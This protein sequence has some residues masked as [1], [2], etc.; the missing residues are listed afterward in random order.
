MRRGGRTKPT[1]GRGRKMAHGGT[2]HCGHPGQPPCPGGGGYRRGG[3]A[4]PAPKR[5]ARGGR[6][7]PAPR[8]MARGGRPS[9]RRMARGGNIRRMPHG[10]QIYSQAFC[11]AGTYRT[12]DGRCTKMGS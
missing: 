4:R 5:M 10:G 11:P 8:R 7:R 12:A 6:T 2:S 3:R 1:R 9:P